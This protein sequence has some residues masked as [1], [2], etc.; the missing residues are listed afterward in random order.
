MIVVVMLVG[1]E[2]L[3][4]KDLMSRSD[5]MCVLFIKTSNSW[6]ELGRNLPESGISLSVDKQL[7]KFP[8]TVALAQQGLKRKC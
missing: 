1:C 8:R 2:N 7:R 3:V 6:L 5:P 4:D